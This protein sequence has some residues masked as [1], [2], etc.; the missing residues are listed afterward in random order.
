MIAA[1]LAIGLLLAGPSPEPAAGPELPDCAGVVV[2][3]DFGEL[4]GGS[5]AGCAA[6]S[7]ATG[8]EALQQ[9]G[10]RIGYVPR[11][12]GMVCSVDQLP[13]PC[14]G[15]PATAYWSYWREQNGT[16][17]YSQ[18][19]PGGVEPAPGVVEGWV[20]GD[21]RTAPRE[22]AAMISPT[23][24][25]AGSWW[26]AV[27]GGLAV[28]LLA[29]A[30]FRRSRG[31]RRSAPARSPARV[32]LLPA[33]GTRVHPG[34]WWCWALLLA[35][36]AASTTQPLLLAT[37]L[38]V[39]GLVVVTHRDPAAGNG[40]GAFLRLGLIVL[41][42]RTVF[43]L[44][45]GG[46]GGATVLFELPSVP[47]PSWLAGIRLGGPVYADALVGS[48]YDALR[49]AVLLCCIGAA[50]TL[51][52]PRRLLPSLPGAL[53]E[54]GVAVVVAISMAP[55][56]INS[57]RRVRRAQQLRGGAVTGR[58]PIRRARS[59]L[60]VAAPVLADA[61][62]RALSL[63][64]SMDARGYGRATALPRRTRVLTGTLLLTGAV[65]LCVAAFALL[66]ADGSAVALA[67][68]G[69]GVPAVAGGLALGGR[70]VR[71]TRFRQ[72]TWTRADLLVVVAGAVALGAT[73]VAGAIGAPLDPVQLV[74]PPVLPLL[75]FL[76]LLVA[77]VPALGR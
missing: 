17:T 75:P 71:R 43:H 55:E 39:V 54:V 23:K 19:G 20:F 7:P 3:V 6:D 10:F 72:S 5:Q 44:L 73:L 70:R 51:A 14:N 59:W 50:I 15:A 52:D 2:V 77:A 11:V 57:A 27:A 42:I 65:A 32:P 4:G 40:F 63:A 31:H 28:L 66:A 36:A 58:G 76:G 62:D 46:G 37:E 18:S 22:P 47:L 61:T 49:L 56:L 69:L 41:A 68:G 16:W 24:P 48:L 1:A 38:A 34:A 74:A 53:Y 35:I 67:A 64:A 45:L 12:P 29:G 8:L 33:I 9:A 13:D 26:P 25:A 21:G 60:R 30:A